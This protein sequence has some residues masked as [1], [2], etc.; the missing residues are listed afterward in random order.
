MVKSEAMQE[1]VQEKSTVNLD[2]ILNKARANFGKTEK[3]L[4]LQ[5]AT[6]ASIHRPTKDSDFICWPDSHWQILTGTR[7]LAYGRITQISGRPDS[8]KSSHAMQFMKLAQDQGAVVILWD[9][10]NKFSPT[11]FDKFFGGKSDQLLIITSKMILEGATMVEHL[12]NSITS[13]YPDKK[14]LVIWDS[15]GG[16]LS[17]SEGE[18]DMK[19]SLQMAEAAKDNGRVMRGLVRLMEE[20]KN[21]LNG[22]EKIA[23]L[24]INQ[25]YA[26]I[27]APGQKESGGQKV[28]FFSSIILQLTRKSDLNKVRD[29]I[30]RRIG[31]V[32]RAKVKKNHLF[33]GDDSVAELELAV[34]AGGITLYT[35][36]KE[37]GAESDED[38]E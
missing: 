9:S 2:A 34:T 23:V 1:K 22:E 13:S 15:V 25:S 32:T 18:K 27:G 37:D 26:N 36:I 10:E 19:D 4:S 11:R 16:T 30:K 24:L 17:R 20:S 38:E 8:G 29:G 5:M 21:K 6:G 31:I 28:E 33:D 7:G 12:I 14:I 35:K 3:G